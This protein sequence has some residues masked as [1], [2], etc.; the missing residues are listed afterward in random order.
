[1]NRETVLFIFLSFLSI[2]SQARMPGFKDVTS[3][4]CVL[5]KQNL[6]REYVLLIELATPPDE[7]PIY[8]CK[9]CKEKKGKGEDVAKPLYG[10]FFYP[11]VHVDKDHTD[12]YYCESIFKQSHPKLI[13]P[14]VSDYLKQEF[15]HAKLN[16]GYEVVAKRTKKGNIIRVNKP[17][18]G[19]SFY[20]VLRGSF[21]EGKDGIKED[22]LGIAEIIPLHD[23]FLFVPE[24]T[25]SL[26]A[27]ATLFTYDPSDDSVSEGGRFRLLKEDGGLL[28]EMEKL[29]EEVAKERGWFNGYVGPMTE[30]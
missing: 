20:I 21:R 27:P 6:T 5:C 25:Q 4:K 23:K 13:N 24:Q 16:N 18:D 26:D 2:Q 11:I 8:I 10:H 28:Y 19:G 1:M 15:M 30:V 14:E 12:E 7:T 29:D 9:Q 3:F 22:G 17:N